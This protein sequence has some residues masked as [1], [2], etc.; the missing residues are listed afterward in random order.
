MIPRPS[1]LLLRNLLWAAVIFVLCT[2]PGENIP[3]PGFSFPHLDKLVH[4]GMFFILA[5]FLT[6]ELHYQTRLKR[7]TIY[8]IVAGISGLYGGAIEVMQELWFLRSGELWDWMADLLG[9]LAGC[10]AYPFVSRQKD[11]LL[12]CFKSK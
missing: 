11:R 7:R 6:S 8:W 4:F 1:V 2:L 12:A 10:W 5:I 9:A 3:K